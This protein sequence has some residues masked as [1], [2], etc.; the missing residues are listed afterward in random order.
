[1][2]P[3]LKKALQE[4][5]AEIPAARLT[6]FPNNPGTI[7]TD[8]NF[9]FDMQGLTKTAWN[10]QI[11]ANKNAPNT[12][13]AKAAPASV[14]AVLVDFTAVFTAEQVRAAFAVSGRDGTKERIEG[15]QAEANEP[16]GAT[17]LAL[18]T[19]SFYI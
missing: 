1:M 11:Q 2:A 14:A 13:V 12:S 10:L 8:A 17:R 16:S 4:F 6:G 7:Y 3:S 9:R 19:R 15:P 18:L 5:I